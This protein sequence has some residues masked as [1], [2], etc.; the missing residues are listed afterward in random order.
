LIR[1]LLGLTITTWIGLNA[2]VR[3]AEMLA[4]APGA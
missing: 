3:S 2:N 4:E 1:K